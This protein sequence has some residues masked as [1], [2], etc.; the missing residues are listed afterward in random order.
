MDEVMV[1]SDGYLTQRITAKGHQFTADE[2][3]ESGGGGLGPDPYSLLLGALG[4]CTSMTIQMYA[5]RKQYPLEKVQVRLSHARIY[6]KDCEECE[7]KEGMVAR[8]ER[9]ITLTGAL[10]EEQKARLLEIAGRCP[11]ART[12]TS[13]VVIKDFLA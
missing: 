1:T 4:A 11:V 3:E 8:I 6:A 2:P 12:I 10:S 13:E 5:K 9:Y 7:S